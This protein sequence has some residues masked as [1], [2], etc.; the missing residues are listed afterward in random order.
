MVEESQEVEVDEMVQAVEQIDLHGM[1]VVQRGN[2][3]GL[4][5]SVSTR[6]IEQMSGFPFPVSGDTSAN[7]SPF[8]PDKPVSRSLPATPAAAPPSRSSTPVSQQMTRTPRVLL[9]DDNKINLKLLQTF[10]RKR[11]YNHI[12][13]AED[14]AQAVT[15]FKELLE[16]DIPPQ[17]IF[18]DVSMPV[19]DGFQSTRHIRELEAQQQRK[20]HPAVMSN[21]D[22]T[23]AEVP[24]SSPVTQTTQQ[25]QPC[26]I[27]ALTGLASTRDQNEAFMSGMDLYLT[28][29]IP[30]KEVAK[31]LDNWERTGGSSTG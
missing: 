16:Q 4:A 24:P 19:M 3:A 30:F 20:L 17:L 29:P 28:K 7:I 26:T 15:S 23:A 22:G 9:V 14:G 25:G 10:M 13:T 8:E 21:V 18:M 12:F 27:I 6:S 11:G 2:M 1:Q 5:S 31:L